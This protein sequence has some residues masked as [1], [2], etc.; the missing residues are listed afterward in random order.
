MKM[1][2]DAFLSSTGRDLHES[3]IRKMGTLG[4]R[5]PDLVSFAAGFPDPVSFPWQ[6]LREIAAERLSGADPAVLQYG[7]TR[8]YKPL[9]EAI[10]GVMANRGIRTTIDELIVSTGSQQ[11]LDL[12]AR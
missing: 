12:V 2:Y 10:V 9:L 11:G 1:N 6:E 8:G 3:A 7:A 5:V 4:V